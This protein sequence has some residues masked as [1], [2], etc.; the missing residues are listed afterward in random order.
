MLVQV[1]TF[2]LFTVLNVSVV[3]SQSPFG[4]QVACAVKDEGAG[5]GRGLSHFFIENAAGRI[6]SPPTPPAY[7]SR[8]FAAPWI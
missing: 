4:N 1:D 7:S 8:S 2:R 3:T 5:A 6:T